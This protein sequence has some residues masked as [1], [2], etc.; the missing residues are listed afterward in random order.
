MADEPVRTFVT[1]PER[2]WPFQEFM[3]RAGG[4]DGDAEISDVEFRGAE[5]PRSARRWPRRSRAAGSS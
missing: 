2:T 5:P 3:I 1:T 4:K